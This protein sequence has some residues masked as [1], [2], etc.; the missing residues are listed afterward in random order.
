MHS[1]NFNNAAKDFSKALEIKLEEFQNIENEKIQISDLYY[2][3]G[4]TFAS[5]R[6]YNQSLKDFEKALEF[7]SKNID[8]K[9]S[10]IR[11]SKIK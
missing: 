11:I 3:R 5:L 7:N 1:Q 2:L 9:N 4:D 10:I 6:N 8:A